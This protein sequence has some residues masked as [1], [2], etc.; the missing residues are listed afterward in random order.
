ME[1]LGYPEFIDIN[2]TEDD[3]S[4]FWKSLIDKINEV[5]DHINGE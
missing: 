4:V 3:M 2:D 1:K 5:I